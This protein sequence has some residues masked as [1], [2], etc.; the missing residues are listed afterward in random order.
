MSD[1]P[2][3]L[4]AVT[5][6]AYWACVVGLVIRSHLRFGTAA[7]AIAHTARE[8]RMWRLW[9][10]VVLLWQILP[11]L[12]AHSSH[13]VWGLPALAVQHQGLWAARLAAA[14]VGVLALLGTIPCW[15]GMGRNWSMAV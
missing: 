6:W 14:A 10:P 8:R 3:T 15:L 1:L 5:V 2:A 7:G 4:V 11:L 9:V 12:A 13:G